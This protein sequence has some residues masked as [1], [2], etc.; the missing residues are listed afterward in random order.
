MINNAHIFRTPIKFWCVMYV[1]MFNLYFVPTTVPSGKLVN[2][3]L[4]LYLC[5]FCLTP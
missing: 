4:F 3:Y 5:N 1:C 2:T